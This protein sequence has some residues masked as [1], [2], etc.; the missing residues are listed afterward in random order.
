MAQREV[1]H[2]YTVLARDSDDGGWPVDP[3][4]GSLDGAVVTGD[5]TLLV[6]DSDTH[7][8]RKVTPA[9]AVTS[10]AGTG[11]R[12]CSGDGG[13]ADKAELMY[14]CDA[15]IDGP[16][17]VYIADADARVVRKVASGGTITTFAGKS[18]HG[19]YTG[20]GGK[21]VDA[22]IGT[23]GGVTADDQN[24]VYIA[25]LNHGVVRK[26][27]SGGTIST[28]AGSGTNG[29]TGDGGKATAAQLESPSSLAWDVVNKRLYIAGTETTHV[30]VVTSDGTINTVGGTGSTVF[31][32]PAGVAVD[33]HGVLFVASRGDTTSGVW[34]V[35]GT[36]AK[37]RRLTGL[38]NGP[39][40]EGGLASGAHVP[41]AL[42][43]SVNADGDLYI[44]QC[45]PCRVRLIPQPATPVALSVPAWKAF[46]GKAAHG[47]HVALS[48]KVSND[49]KGTAE[50]VSAKVVLP[51]GMS[52]VGEYADTT[53]TKVWDKETRTLTPNV[54]GSL[55]PGAH[56]WVTV[57]ASVDGDAPEKELEAS[58]TLDAEGLTA[59]PTAPTAKVTVVGTGGA[60][61]TVEP[62]DVK[63]AFLGF[64]AL[65]D[66]ETGGSGS[67]V[68]GIGGLI[69]GIGGAAASTAA[70][71]AGAAIAAVTAALGAI[72][73]LFSWLFGG[74]ATLSFNGG[75]SP[76]GSSGSGGSDTD[77]PQPE[78]EDVDDEEKKENITRLWFTDA[79]C[80]PDKSEPG[81]EVTLVWELKNTGPKDDATS[82]AATVTLPDTLTLTK[83]SGDKGTWTSTDVGANGTIGTLK[84][85]ETATVT[86][87]AT[88]GKDAAS[89]TKN[90]AATAFGAHATPAYKTVP[91]AVAST[92]ELSV[93]KGQVE[94]Q[95]AEQEK[96][97]TYTWSLSAPGATASKVVV[98]ITRPAT[99]LD[100]PKATVDGHDV[101]FTDATAT[102]QLPSDLAP[103]DRPVT[104]TLSGKISKNRSEDVAATVSATAQGM[105]SPVT[106]TATANLKPQSTS[107]RTWG[108]IL[109]EQLTAGSGA[110]YVWTVANDGETELT[111]V[112]LTAKLPPTG[113]AVNPRATRGGTVA[114][115]KATW[116]AGTIGTLKAKQRWTATV[117]VDIPSDA[118]GTLPPVTAEAGAQGGAK[119]TSNPVSATVRTRTA[120][121]LTGTVA[122]GRVVVDAATTF[123]WSAVNSGPSTLAGAALKI[124]LPPSL[125]PT[126]ATVNGTS[127]TPTP[128]GDTVTVPLPPAPPSTARPTVITLT[129]TAEPGATG[130]LP[131]RAVL[132]APTLATGRPAIDT[133]VL[134]VGK[135]TLQ[136]TPVPDKPFLVPAGS[137][138]RLAW[139]AACQG[140]TVRGA[141]FTLTPPTGIT[142]LH[143]RAG[144][145]TLDLT[146]NPTTVTASLGDLSAPAST[147]IEAT[148]ALDADLDSP[149]ALPAALTG[150]GKDNTAHATTDL[151][152]Y[153]AT[154]LN[155]QLAQR[156]DPAA[157]GEDHAFVWT[158][159]NTGPSTEPA[160]TLVATASAGLTPLAAD[161][162]AQ[163]NGQ[164]VTWNALPALTVGTAW[165]L[166]VVASL[167]Q[168]ASKPSWR[169]GL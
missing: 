61:W 88:V 12:G 160:R 117:E 42:S 11:T 91:V 81:K 96:Q 15:A 19:G 53:D 24:N 86:V 68:G 142:V 139:T 83:V 135:D 118:T 124:T 66:T 71:A 76:F 82:V 121:A 106:D 134:V 93:T 8:V 161:P 1:G 23:P 120:A 130:L 41:D 169:L 48:W 152:V 125:T 33:R 65:K 101:A 113:R 64:G 100:D 162:P 99:G 164:T 149:L 30:R 150:D 112:T 111:E 102:Y 95:P 62:K 67:L 32:Q 39:L 155:R 140:S 123:T 144:G 70:A 116:P 73:S 110:T 105:S 59:A 4:L 87:T 7:R 131:T 69:G 165:T 143:I 122:P 56:W 9:G 50:G 154:E 29:Y 43:V 10:F 126:G 163:I 146:R 137:V 57:V 92:A 132:T 44:G 26:V 18:G 13:S 104:I 75:F 25:D 157:P 78:S 38:G 31:G 147:S 166:T 156:P 63:S 168:S 60:A 148:I 141:V 153:R 35:P 145:V 14:P 79:S 109:P 114:D 167:D 159:T 97:V 129:A 89:G 49:G 16:G 3:T 47:S 136:L 2:I 28:F 74:T 34:M 72:S 98:T 54:T 84:P 21:A 90:A 108:S 55:R 17:N 107:L 127:V 36:D 115:G 85:N 20:D 22:E 138:Q 94:P 52:P 133:D 103:T 6:S 119:D 158:L 37:P 45:T 51:V 58:L 151:R 40:G 27:D 5:G 77:T 128:V 80:K 46:P